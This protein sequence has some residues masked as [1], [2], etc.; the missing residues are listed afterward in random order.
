[1]NQILIADD[2]QTTRDLFSSFFKD[3]GYEAEVFQDGNSVLAH[4]SSNRPYMLLVNVQMPGI[5]GME[6]LQQSLQLYPDLPVIVISCYADKS[7]ARQAL[8]MGAYDFF[9]TPLDLD[10]VELRLSAKLGL[11]KMTGEAGG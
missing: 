9:L 3:R 7:L 10:T 4:L 8:R 5:S 2:D 6:I 1:M 11:L